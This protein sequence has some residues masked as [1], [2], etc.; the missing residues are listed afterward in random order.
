VALMGGSDRV[1]AEAR[2]ALQG[3][4]PQYAAELAQLVVSADPANEDA[5][6]LKAAALRARG[7]AEL[8]PIARSWY[9]T[10]ALELEGAFDPNQVVA[11]GIASLAGS[12]PLAEVVRNW[13]YRIDAARA[14]AEPVAIDLRVSD[15][16]ES[17]RLLL[18]NGVLIVDGVDDG[19]ADATIGMPAA[20]ARGLAEEPTLEAPDIEV[21]GD[22]AAAERLI[23]AFAT[24]APDFAMHSR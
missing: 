8:N 4:D 11:Q 20:R 16:G 6:L 14:G 17:F 18:R 19:D 15:T 7:Y 1:L 23:D 12:M 9:L 5:R 2:T 10:G 13:R 24:S 22:R 21:S 3:D